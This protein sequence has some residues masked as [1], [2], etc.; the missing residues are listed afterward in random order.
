[1]PVKAKPLARPRRSKADTQRE[2][3]QIQ[4]ES[5][6]AREGA[7]QKVQQLAKAR[8]AE[9]IQSLDG[10]SVEG[11]VQRIST[12]GVGISKALADIS[13]KLVEE[14]QRLAAVREAVAIERREQ[15]Q[16]HRID[17]AAT[18][19]DQ[20]NPGLPAREGASRRRDRG[21]ASG[22]GGRVA[23]NRT[24]KE[25]NRRA[26]AQAPPARERRLRIQENP[27]TQKG[28]GQV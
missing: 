19:L 3:D 9:V 14:V 17:V 18:S 23:R 11:E 16:L 7:D 28:A 4:T 13:G 5:G 26:V 27:G 15:E 2:F 12:L 22:V 24:R 21:T 6:E 1:M 20:L 25:G 8:E 10:I